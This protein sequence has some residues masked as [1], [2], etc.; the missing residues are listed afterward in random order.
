MTP[1]TKWLSRSRMHTLL[2]MKA[3][4]NIIKQCGKTSHTQSLWPCVPPFLKDLPLYPTLCERHTPLLDPLWKTNILL[5]I[6]SSVSW[7]VFN[8]NRI[9]V[10]PHLMRAQSAYKSIQIHIFITFQN[11]YTR[12]QTYTH[13]WHRQ[14]PPPP[15]HT[16]MST[17]AQIACTN[18]NTHTTHALTHCKHIHASDG[19]GEKQKKEKDK[20]VCRRG[21]FSVMDLQEESEETHLTEIFMI[22]DSHIIYW[23]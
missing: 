5:W 19:F 20:P 15:T 17:S 3:N 11:T 9:F 1:S 18:T 2:L 10:A 23:G 21:G 7:S 22:E 12:T 6:L 16:H 13:M 8:N 14:P 4:T